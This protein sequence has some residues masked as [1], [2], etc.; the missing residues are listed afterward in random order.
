[1][2]DPLESLNIVTGT[3][4]ILGLY[5]GWIIF[6]SL[7][8]CMLSLLKGHAY[9]PCVITYLWRPYKNR[10]VEKSMGQED[11]HS[12][13]KIIRYSNLFHAILKMCLCSGLCP[14]VGISQPDRGSTTSLLYP[15]QTKMFWMKLGF[16][17]SKTIFE[18]FHVPL[19]LQKCNRFE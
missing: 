13:T 8:N 7:G 6:F 11:T 4:C 14:T 5:T 12:N 15:K 1:M 3:F 9:L 10:G 19:T 17:K 2:E 16:K 18:L